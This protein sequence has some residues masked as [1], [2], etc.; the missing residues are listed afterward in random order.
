[1]TLVQSIALANEMTMH[2]I[3]ESL[4]RRLAEFAANPGDPVELIRLLLED[5]KISRDNKRASRLVTKARFRRNCQLEDWDLSFDRGISKAQLKELALL[6]FFHNREHLILVGGT[7]S[8]KTHLAISLGHRLCQ[9]GV[10]TSFASMNLLLEE[11][12]AQRAAGK[13]LNFIKGLAKTTVLILDDFGL[14]SYQHDEAMVLMDILEERYRKGG[15]I[16]TSQV[17]PEGWISLFEDKV[18]AE[19]IV[20]RIRNPS[21][22]LFIKGASYRGKEAKNGGDKKLKFDTTK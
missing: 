6:S 3:S 16:I 18:T 4:E 7:G 22:Q 1:M 15:L 10:S 12:S 8:G 19:A 17:K 2:G 14:R 21:V 11:V 13:Y 9:Q 20:D 5:E